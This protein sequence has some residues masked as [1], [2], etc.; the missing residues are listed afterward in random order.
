MYIALYQNVS[1]FMFIYVVS[2]GQYYITVV[3]KVEKKA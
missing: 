2:L 1:L 3:S